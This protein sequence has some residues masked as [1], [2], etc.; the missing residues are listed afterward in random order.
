MITGPVSAGARGVRLFVVRKRVDT[1][2]SGSRSWI[3]L[4]QSTRDAFRRTQAVHEFRRVASNAYH[5]KHGTKK[6]HCTLQDSLLDS[7][8]H[9]EGSVHATP[10]A[11]FSCRP[12]MEPAN[13]LISRPGRRLEGFA[14]G[15][16]SRTGLKGVWRSVQRYLSGYLGIW[17]LNSSH[18]SINW[19]CL[20][21]KRHDWAAAYLH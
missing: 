3:S 16:V 19:L 6:T 4:V 10:A 12:G 21:A 18:L 1:H 5:S 2:R 15:S 11:W 13:H 20:R 7:E 17:I 8:P 9:A 14:A